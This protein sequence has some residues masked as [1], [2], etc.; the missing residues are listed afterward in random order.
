MFFFVVVS[1]VVAAFVAA[2]VALSILVCDFV[3][4]VDSASPLATPGVVVVKV[5]AHPSAVRC[6]CFKGRQIGIF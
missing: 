5:V 4:V 6:A 1:V 3:P 2:S